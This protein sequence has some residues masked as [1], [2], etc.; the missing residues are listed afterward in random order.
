MYQYRICRYLPDLNNPAEQLDFAIA[1]VSA[2]EV[3][4]VGVDLSE[5]CLEDQH[6]F[7]RALTH[8]SFDVIWNRVLSILTRERPESGYTVL[9]HLRNHGATNINLSGVFETDD[10]EPIRDKAFSIFESTMATLRKRQ[11]E[12]I[13]QEWQEGPRTLER[14]A[15]LACCTS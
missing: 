3:A 2:K 13:Q 6:P 1:I 12:C 11:A 8:N 10:D 5:Y 4:L 14:T 7:D 15:D 9:E